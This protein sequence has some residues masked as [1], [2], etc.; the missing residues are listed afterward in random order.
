MNYCPYN[1][2][3][4]SRVNVG[5]NSLCRSE[6]RIDPYSREL[7]MA[8]SDIGLTTSWASGS[9][10]DM[11]SRAQVVTFIG[12]GG[13]TT[14]CRSVTKELESAGEQVIA[15]TTTKVLPEE[16]MIAWKN[17]E[18]PPLEQEGAC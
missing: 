5:V 3:E 7:N 4:T 18:P 12:A 2:V 1:K 6:G 13:K 9:L 14:C 16:H 8:N 17:T 15:T 10:W 11:T